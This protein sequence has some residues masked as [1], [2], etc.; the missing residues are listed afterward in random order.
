MASNYFQDETEFATPSD[1]ITKENYCIYAPSLEH[2]TT[3]FNLHEGTHQLIF[4]LVSV[5]SLEKL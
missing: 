3:F 5:F 2:Y 1:I 4:E